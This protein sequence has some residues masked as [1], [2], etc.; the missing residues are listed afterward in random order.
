M[1]RFISFFPIFIGYFLYLHFK[2]LS[3][4]LVP[5]RPP[6]RPR[7]SPSHPPSPA[8]MR[9]FPYPPTHSLFPPLLPGISLHWGIEPSQDQGPVLTLM[10]YRAILC[11]LCGWSHGSL[12]VCSLVGDLVPGSS[13]KSGWLILLFFLWGS[14]PLQLLQPFL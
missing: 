9:V 4:F 8:S 11:Y 6:P 1:L 14:K 5:P 10:L 12:H 13:W 3:P 2:M 7:N